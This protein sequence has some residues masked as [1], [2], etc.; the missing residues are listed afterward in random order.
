[1][2]QTWVECFSRASSHR[3]KAKERKAQGN[4]MNFSLYTNPHQSLFYSSARKKHSRYTAREYFASRLLCYSLF[5]EPSC[6]W[7]EYSG[8]CL[9]QN[10]IER[11]DI[12]IQ[13]FYCCA[14]RVE[15]QNNLS[16]IFRVEKQNLWRKCFR[17]VLISCL[18][19]FS[20]FLL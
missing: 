18:T 9:L 1:M 13:Q 6:Q 8:A 3:V 4:S 20:P 17:N 15:K 14:S 5:V 19:F 2:L 10:D 16:R 7:I 12:E 11:G